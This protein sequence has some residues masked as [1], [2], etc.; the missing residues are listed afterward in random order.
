MHYFTHTTDSVQQR[1][2][3][4]IGSTAPSAY[5]S[6]ACSVSRCKCKEIGSYARAQEL[7]REGHSYLDRS[8]D[9]IACKSL[10]K[11]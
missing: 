5:G 3:P 4:A 11:G 10:R 8:G 2:G 6:P 9:G 7:L 1:P